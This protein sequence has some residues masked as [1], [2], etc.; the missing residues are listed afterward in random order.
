MYPGPTS[1]YMIGV[2]RSQM[3]SGLTGNVRTDA[4]D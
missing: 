3:E 2:E 4:Q 1:I